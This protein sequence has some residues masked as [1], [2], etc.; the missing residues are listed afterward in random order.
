MRIR[1]DEI[2]PY[3]G[4]IHLHGIDWYKGI[5]ITRRQ[6]KKAY[7]LTKGNLDGY[8]ET[9]DINRGIN[10]FS[11]KVFICFFFISFVSHLFFN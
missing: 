2:V 1:N 6:L 9:E 8:S 4:I 10:P 7:V 3:G 11:K 5:K